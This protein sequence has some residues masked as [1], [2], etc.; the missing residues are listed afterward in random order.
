MSPASAYVCGARPMVDRPSTIEAEDALV[1]AYDTSDREAVNTA[2]KKDARWRRER[3][4]VVAGLMDLKQGRAW[5]YALL[6]VCH[7]YQSPFY[8]G[9]PHNTSFRCG[10]HNIGLRLL[11]D[12]QAAAPKQYIQMIEEAAGR[13]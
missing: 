3:L 12:V 10:E 1:V 7:I 5:M 9:D 4:E 8:Q 11:A 6:D 2:R 13:V